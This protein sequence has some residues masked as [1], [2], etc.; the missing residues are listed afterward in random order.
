MNDH[1]NN[2]SGHEILPYLANDYLNTL[3]ISENDRNDV[4]GGMRKKIE[5]ALKISFYC[6]RCFIGSGYTRHFIRDFFNNKSIIGTIVKS[7]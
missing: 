2:Q 7:D 5:T 3:E 1:P 4:S 6:N